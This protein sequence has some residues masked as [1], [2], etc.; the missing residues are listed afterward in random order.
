MT[1]A[2][3]N[4]KGAGLLAGQRVAFTGRLLTMR[5]QDAYQR[6][7]EAGGEPVET[8]SRRTQFLVVGMQGWSMLPDGAISAKLQR[9]EALRGA[10]H[11]IEILSE[12]AFIERL[13]GKTVV[14][15]SG[16]TCTLAHACRILGVAEETIRRFE[17]F[18]LVQVSGGAYD[19]QDLVGLRALARLVQAG[20][21]PAAI[22][23]GFGQ[24]VRFLPDADRP[25]AQA[26]LIVE[27]EELVAELRGARINARGQLLLDLERTAGPGKALPLAGQRAGNADAWVARGL[28]CEAQEE[29]ALAERAYRCAL[30][31]EEDF[32]EAHFNLANVLRCQGNS[33]AAER[34][35]RQSLRYEP[36]FVFAWYNL[37]YLLDEQDRLVEAA[38]ALRRALAVFP[39]F[40]DAH[41]NLALCCQRLGDRQQAIVHWR[42]YL[43]LDPDGECAEAAHGHLEALLA[44]Q[45]ELSG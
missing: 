29:W 36:G 21:S 38:S 9:A 26:R 8:V 30:A 44:R 24:L 31:V 10:G 28:A 14:G 16:T 42:A 1:F 11:G 19:F 3:G 34:H 23:R 37:A 32:A 39:G 27:A 4:E 41:F 18:G 7:R 25:F 2:A 22:A 12:R 13:G 43:S 33:E 40:A 15:A 45:E 5:R 20:T 35:Y 17:Q 6:V